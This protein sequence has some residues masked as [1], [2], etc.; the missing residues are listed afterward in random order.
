MC[1][2]KRLRDSKY[3]FAIKDKEI[4][5]FQNDLLNENLDPLLAIDE[6]AKFIRALLLTEV[7]IFFKS[8]LHV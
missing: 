7:D 2:A 1:R 8:Y 5:S 6:D 3:E 4:K